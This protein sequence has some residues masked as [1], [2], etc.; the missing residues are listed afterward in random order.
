MLAA[1][2]LL[3]V[4][5]TL[6]VFLAVLLVATVAVAA[7]AHLADGHERP[8]ARAVALAGLRAAVQLAAVSALIGWVVHAV[9]LLLGFVL[10]MFAVAV[11]TA[12]RR[13]TDDRTWWWAAL[14]IAAGVLPVVAALLL[15]GLVPLK[16]VALIPITGILIGGGMTATVLAGRRALDELR[17]RHGE[18]EAALALGLLD[19]DARLEIARPVASDALLPGLDQTR[20]VGLVTLPGAFVGMLLGGASPLL[21]GA[22]QLFVLVALMAVQVV[23]VAVTLELVARGLLRRVPRHVP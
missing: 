7:A 18:V 11:R 23:A 12:G 8:Y 4:N 3:P 5:T 15:T 14:P 17:T 1:A 22:V 16:G 2:A 21:A 10:L 9:P 19:R 6:G 20:T 13:I